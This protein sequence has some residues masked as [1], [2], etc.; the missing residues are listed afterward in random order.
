MY[1]ILGIKFILQDFHGNM[2][3]QALVHYVKLFK[4]GFESIEILT[5]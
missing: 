5:C 4:L 3:H 2:E 1:C